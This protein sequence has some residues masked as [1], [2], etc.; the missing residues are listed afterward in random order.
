[1]I[2]SR[3]ARQH[4][5]RTLKENRM[6]ISTDKYKSNTYRLGPFSTILP[7]GRTIVRWLIR[8]FTLTEEDLLG[9]GIYLGGKEGEE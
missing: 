5:R 7:T 2:K 3:G 1:M 4:P 9:A 8:F 6:D